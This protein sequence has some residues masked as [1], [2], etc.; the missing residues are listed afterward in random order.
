ML[1]NAANV[2]ITSP[3]QNF[4]AIGKS[5]LS[6]IISVPKTDFQHKCQILQENHY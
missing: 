1:L 2:I 6:Q 4:Q 5:C 3:F